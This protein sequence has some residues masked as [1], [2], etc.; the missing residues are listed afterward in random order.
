MSISFPRTDIMS[1]CSWTPDGEPWDLKQRQE[2]SRT[3]GGRTLAKDFG[4]GLWTGGFTSSPL[5][6]DD[7]FDLEAALNSLDGSINTFEARDLRRPYPKLSPSGTFGD[8]G[9]IYA[10]QNNKSLRITGLDSAF[11]ISRGDYLSFDYDG[12]RY[13]H[14]A[15][16]TVTAV[17]GLTPYFEVRPYIKAGLVLSPSIAVKLKQPSAVCALVPSSIQKRMING[18]QG[19]ISF[20]AMQVLV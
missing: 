12:N 16:E 20:Q 3:A 10:V 4:I 13:L 5:S 2:M 7:M 17:A 6:L 18:V 14:Q 19:T 1:L 15:M 8:T 9:T 11:I